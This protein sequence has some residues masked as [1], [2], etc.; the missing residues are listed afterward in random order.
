VGRKKVTL[1]RGPVASVTRRERQTC[2]LASWASCAHWTQ[3]KAERGGGI[4]GRARGSK[5]AAGEDW[6]A[7]PKAREG[8]ET[9]FFSFSFSNISKHFQLILNPILN[10]NQTTPTKN[11]NATA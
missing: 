1:T 9:L 7:G 3:P 8:S 10:L 6:A 5:R 4:T 2:A 11:S